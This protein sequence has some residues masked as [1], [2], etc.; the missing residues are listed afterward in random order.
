MAAAKNA[1]G[2]CAGYEDIFCQQVKGQ[3]G[4]GGVAK[5]I[6]NG[7]QLLRNLGRAGDHVGGW[8]D[9]ILRKCAVAVDADARGIFA[10]VP[11]AGAAV[12]AHTTDNVSLAGDQLTDVVP[13]DGGTHFHNFAHILMPGGGADTEGILRPLVPVPD[14]YVCAANGGLMDFNHDV[15]FAYGGNL[16]SLHGKAFCWLIFDQCPHGS[17]VQ[18]DHSSCHI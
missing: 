1:D 12:A 17:S 15:I 5:G 2:T 8:N 3:G 18:F 7:V 13:L 9:Q 4:V 6:E 16:Y 10:Q 14:M 11:P